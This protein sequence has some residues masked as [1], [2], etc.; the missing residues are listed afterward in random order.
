[1]PI[2]RRHS[3][4]HRHRL[5][6]AVWGCVKEK[7]AIRNYA[8][9]K[10]IAVEDVK[11]EDVTGSPLGVAGC[12]A[13]VMLVRV[14]RSYPPPVNGP[15]ETRQHVRSLCDRLGFDYDGGDS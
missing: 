2:V 15:R 7:R 8:M 12:L 6:N 4:H 13:Q 10:R 9:V 1:M 3:P 14:P 11:L 5:H